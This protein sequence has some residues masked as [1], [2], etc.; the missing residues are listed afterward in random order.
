MLSSLQ[1]NN[2]NN[3]RKEASY[4]EM[5]VVKD[6]LETLVQQEG[7]DKFAEN[8]IRDCLRKI[9][10][11]D[12]K[13]ELIVLECLVYISQIIRGS[14][15]LSSKIYKNEKLTSCCRDLLNDMNLTYKE[16]EPRT[17]E[18]SIDKLSNIVFNQYTTKTNYI[19]MWKIINK[20]EQMKLLGR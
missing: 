9:N 17:L 2:V 13:G 6:R 19:L 12:I 14:K 4:Q 1:L 16:V 3:Y 5:L 18:D 11:S 8:C 20:Y 7:N 15:L 10:K